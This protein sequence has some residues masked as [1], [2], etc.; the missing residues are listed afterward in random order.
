MSAFIDALTVT[1]R[2]LVVRVT[3][4]KVY[5]GDVSVWLSLCLP[6]QSDDPDGPCIMG[7]RIS[8]V[9]RA[10]LPR[11][12]YADSCPQLAFADDAKRYSGFRS[13]EHM[14]SNKGN[15]VEQSA[16]IPSNKLQLDMNNFV[17]AWRLDRD[18]D[19]NPCVAS[20]LP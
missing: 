13:F 4:A 12:S 5:K 10:A 9:C 16:L 19:G 11:V 18:D 17:N 15:L 3:G 2:G 1:G 6:W 8:R 14:Y 20:V 7:L